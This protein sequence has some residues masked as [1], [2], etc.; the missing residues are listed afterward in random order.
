MIS[1]KGKFLKILRNIVAGFCQ[2][3]YGFK[4]FVR[5][6]TFKKIFNL[7]KIET[8][9]NARKVFIGSHPYLLTIDAGNVCNLHCP[10]CPTG[11][12]INNRPKGFMNFDDFKHI[13]DQF[14]DY[15]FFITLHNWGEPFLNKDIFK[16]IRYAEDNNAGTIV[17][18]N[19][20]AIA[21]E[22]IDQI[23]ESNLEH[24][25]VSID[26]ATSENY[27]KYR[28]GG[29]FAT[30]L[31]NLKKLT[32][33][34]KKLN[35]KLP[36]IRWQFILNRYNENE[37]EK[38]KDL[39]KKIGVDAFTYYTKFKTYN[40]TFDFNDSLAEQWNPKLHKDLALNCEPLNLFKKPCSF[41]WRSTA[42]NYDGGVSPCCVVCDKNTD[43]GNVLK[44]KFQ[45]IW[46][47]EYYLSSRGFFASPR[48]FLNKKE[49]ICQKCRINYFKN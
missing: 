22:Q 10:Q 28:R 19:L 21:D 34:K 26:G 41:L 37:L 24:L 48:Y 11:M 12:G 46:N 20:N 27:L 14:K 45:D 40:Y 39:A 29:D 47:N 15:L 8:A 32:L 42:I 7:I 16:I 35:R 6:A 31:S 2:I 13:F 49:T 44:E 5:H 3:N 33:K 1:I 43:F 36:F 23:F 38:A 30:V 17:S 25:I 4:F 18:S 9:Y